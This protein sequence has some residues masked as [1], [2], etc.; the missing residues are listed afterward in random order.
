MD[1]NETQL[2]RPVIP[3]ETQQ[4]TAPAPMIEKGKF[5]KAKRGRPTRLSANDAS[6]TTLLEAQANNEPFQGYGSGD[7]NDIP[8]MEE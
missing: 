4:P 3:E 8:Q 6:V 1:L 7:L 5:V 2:D